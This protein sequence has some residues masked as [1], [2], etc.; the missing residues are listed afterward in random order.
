MT[1]FSLNILIYVQIWLPWYS[2][3][4]V[5]SYRMVSRLEEKQESKQKPY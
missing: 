3:M 4:F 1:K 2:V 5:D